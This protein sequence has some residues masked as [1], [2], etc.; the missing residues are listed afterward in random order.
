MKPYISILLS[1]LVLLAGVIGCSKS[2]APKASAGHKRPSAATELSDAQLLYQMGKLDLAEQKLQRVLKA[3][4]DN[5]KAGYYLALVQQ[6]QQR[7]ENGTEQPWGYY[8]TIPQ[9]PIYR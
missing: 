8:Q 5:G 7:R 6:A 9:Q 4:P 2:R 1:S 3:D